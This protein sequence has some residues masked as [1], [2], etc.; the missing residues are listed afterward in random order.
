MTFTPSATSSLS[1][2]AVF[3]ES[4]GQH[5]AQLNE[6]IYFMGFRPGRQ[7]HEQSGRSLK[8]RALKSPLPLKVAQKVARQ[9]EFVVSYCKHWMGP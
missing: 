4:S 1:A 3:W 5:L 6:L 9:N 7:Y 2:G 8:Q